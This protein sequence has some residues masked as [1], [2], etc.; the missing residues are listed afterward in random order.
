M[1]SMADIVVRLLVLYVVI[2]W[3]VD[4]A[5]AVGSVVVNNSVLLVV[6][7]AVVVAS[8]VGLVVL[9]CPVVARVVTVFV[10]IESKVV[11]WCLVFG[12]VTVGSPFGSVVCN[13]VLVI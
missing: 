8:V 5:V 13:S 1:D 10:I 3:S 9:C 2:V 11:A 4:L 12:I 7:V 6:A